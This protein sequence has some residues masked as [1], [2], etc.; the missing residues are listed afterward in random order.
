MYGS[1]G[2]LDY[3]VTRTAKAKLVTIVTTATLTVPT[4]LTTATQSLTP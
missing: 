2:G 3:C 1:A 4:T